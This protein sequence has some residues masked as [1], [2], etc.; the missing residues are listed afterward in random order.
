MRLLDHG[1]DRVGD[2]A[3]PLAVVGGSEPQVKVGRPPG[4]IQVD[5]PDHPWQVRAQLP[6]QTP[7]VGGRRR[8]DVLVVRS[9]RGF[10]TGGGLA[11]EPEA[12]GELSVVGT[13]V[14]D[15]GF[16]WHVTAIE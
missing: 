16:G 9:R 6:A 2:R 14:E 12:L 8:F 13:L 10:G 15:V 11:E 1:K 7:D 5:R 3:Y 4:D